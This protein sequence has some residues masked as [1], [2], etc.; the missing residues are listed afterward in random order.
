[1]KTV[2][3][4]LSLL[5]LSILLAGCG[6]FEWFPDSNPV[7][8]STTTL[9]NGTV[10]VAYNFSM[11]ATGGAGSYTWSW[12]GTTPPG[13]TMSSKGYISG[14][15]TSSGTYTVSVT[16]SDNSTSNPRSASKN[17]SFV[18]SAN[19]LNI[20]TASPLAQAVVQQQYSTTFHASGGI[21]PLYWNWST[22][23]TS[24]CPPAGLFFNT[25]TAKLTGAPKTATSSCSFTVFVRDAANALVDK[26]FTLVVGQ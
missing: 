13:L 24:N 15:P 25:T 18:I 9:T 12:T 1:M 16:A 23:K 5:F 10:G 6:K 11:T 8:I 7:I 19:T 20:T 2:S 26:L 3:A 21:S 17:F 14:T 4:L 22:A